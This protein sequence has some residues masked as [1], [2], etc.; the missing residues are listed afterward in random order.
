M[1]KTKKLVIGTDRTI[2]NLKLGKLGKIFLSS[3]CPA[4]VKEDVV[5][6]SKLSKVEIIKLNYPND[7]V[8]TLCKKPF[9]ISVIGVKKESKWQE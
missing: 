8:G 1:L 6:Y 9:S 4:G 3:N 5:H 7:E 2:K